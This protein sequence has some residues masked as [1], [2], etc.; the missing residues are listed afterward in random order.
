METIRH[1]FQDYVVIDNKIWFSSSIMNGLFCAETDGG[2]AELMGIFPEEEV[3]QFRLYT[4]IYVYENNLVFIPHR[5]NNICIYN[6]YNKSFMRIDSPLSRNERQGRPYFTVQYE[7]KIFLCHDFMKELVVLNM[8][9]VSLQKYAVPNGVRKKIPRF[10]WI[11]CIVD[12]CAYMVVDCF[13]ITIQLSCNEIKIQ[14]IGEGNIHFVCIEYD[15]EKFWIVDD[16]NQ[17]YSYQLG[18][19]SA[20]RELQLLQER[21]EGLIPQI[22]SISIGNKVMWC[23]FNNKNYIVCID[24]ST[25]KKEIVQLPQPDVVPR[26]IEYSYLDFENHQIRI[27]MGGENKH[28]I[29][30]TDTKKWRMIYYK[31]LWEDIAYQYKKC[32]KKENILLDET[33]IGM[34]LEVIRYYLTIQ[35]SNEVSG[36]QKSYGKEIYQY[37]Q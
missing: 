28:W 8:Q 25:M 26:Y 4:D 16:L 17:L 15:G 23:F 29:L 6:L 30:D 13:L 35:N 36:H 22:K 20:K 7:E 10:W 21:W 14:E 3:F 18:E 5:G 34:G 11:K 37:L 9:N 19:K 33:F 12:N 2:N 27:S 32:L 1:M 31:T 24:L